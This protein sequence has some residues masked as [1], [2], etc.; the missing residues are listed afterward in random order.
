MIR[1][2]DRDSDADD[3]VDRIIYNM[4]LSPSSEWTSKI[5]GDAH[6]N[7]VTFKAQ[8]RVTCQSNHYTSSCSVYCKKRDDNAG[9]YDC[10]SSGQKICKSGWSNPST[11]CI[12]RKYMNMSIPMMSTI[13]KISKFP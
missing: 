11:S 6:Y 2:K 1:I 10:G 12:T 7:E 9:H 8:F 3:L 4:N 5:T 13:H